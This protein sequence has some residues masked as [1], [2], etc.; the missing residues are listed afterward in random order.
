MATH[1]SIYG[2]CEHTA[3]D[4]TGTCLRGKT[5][6]ELKRDNKVYMLCTNMTGLHKNDAKQK[7][8]YVEWN[9]DIMHPI[10]QVLGKMKNT[11]CYRKSK[12]YGKKL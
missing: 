4:V 11:L 12:I 3:D 10:Q 2:M 1:L 5:T 6:S 9:L 7:T 8:N